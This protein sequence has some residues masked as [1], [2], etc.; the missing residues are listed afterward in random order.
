MKE[1]SRA[2]RF[3]AEYPQFREVRTMFRETAD[4]IL[5]EAKDRIRPNGSPRR[6]G[7]EIELSCLREDGMPIAQATRD[8]IVDANGKGKIPLFYQKE[9]GAAQIELQ[10]EPVDLGAS[11]GFT[12]WRSAMEHETKRL[13]QQL[14]ECGARPVRFGTDPFVPVD[15]RC[16]TTG[17]LRYRIVPDFHT[18][19]RRRGF[20]KMVGLGSA[21]VR[22]DDPAV[23]GA[24]SSVQFN[25][26]CHSAAEAITLLNRSLVT[27]PYAVAMGGNSRFLDGTDT[28][29]ADIRCVLWDL[30][31]DIRTY[32]EVAQGLSGRSGLPTT[33]YEDIE[34][35]FLDAHDQPS[36]FTP[37]QLQGPAFETGIGL[38]WRDAR[39]K[40][41]R[42]G[43]SDEQIV[44]EFRPVS[45]QPT[46]FEDYAILAFAVG[47]MLGSEYLQ[48]PNL[49]MPYLHDN[50]ASAMIDGMKGMLWVRCEGT[51]AY[52]PA[53]DAVRL[54][55]AVAEEGLQTLGI[56]DAELQDLR[57]TWEISLVDGCPSEIAFARLRR[58]WSSERKDG[59]EPINRDLLLQFVRDEARRALEET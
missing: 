11:G 4:E 20:P 15:D 16:R 31:H 1:K 29:Y 3:D 36:I 39:I 6:I 46:P 57:K 32:G 56:S 44:L 30:S 41:L 40:F 25:L 47:H 21:Q 24:C 18:K 53:G 17:E 19:H 48:I 14:E 10:T 23:V 50:R 28:G 34:D 27:G 45:V 13:V 54:A 26:D 2:E 33:Y 37:A 58:L 12:A 59:S 55:H 5:R 9:L 51:W 42:R 52:L 8:A 22:V 35:F 49:P 38:L 7:V 43:T